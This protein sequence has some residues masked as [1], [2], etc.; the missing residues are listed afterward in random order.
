MATSSSRARASTVTYSESEASAL[1]QQLDTLRSVPETQDQDQIAE[2][3]RLKINAI[4]CVRQSIIN[5]AAPDRI[6]DAFRHQEGFQLCLHVLRISIKLFA[7]PRKSAEDFQLSLEVSISVLSLLSTALQDHW[8]NRKYFRKRVEQ[9]G[10]ATLQ[11]VLSQLLDTWM[12]GDVDI[13]AAQNRLFGALFACAIEGDSMSELFEKLEKH[14]C[15]KQGMEHHPNEGSLLIADRGDYGAIPDDGTL[16]ILKASWDSQFLFHN[17]DAV[18]VALQLWRR[19]GN[20][21]TAGQAPKY[22]NLYLLEVTKY[23]VELST[24]NLLALHGSGILRVVL[25]AFVDASLNL[26]ARLLLRDLAMSLLKIGINE[27]SD[28]HFLYSRAA[29][30][31]EVAELMRVALEQSTTPPFFHFDLSLHGASSIELPDIRHPFPPISGGGY[32]LSIWLQIIR[33]DPES[34]TTIFGAF[35]SSQT[36]F[37]L[38]YLEKDTHNLILQT[39]VTSSKPSVRFKSFVF[40]EGRWYHLCLVHK[41][42]KTTSSSRASLFVDG[43]FVEQIKAQYPA[44]V[45]PAG[46]STDMS[47]ILSPGRKFKPVQ[48][49]LGTP[50]DLAS[51]L[52]NGLVMSQWRLALVHLFNDV[53]S[54]DL[55]AVHKQLG[56]R[57]HGNYQDC[58]G[59]FQTYEASAALNLRNENLHPGKE[60]KSDIVSAIRSKASAILPEAKV[61]LNFSPLSVIFDE[62]QNVLSDAQLMKSLSKAAAKNLRSLSRGGRTVVAVN[63]AVPSIN[64][65]LIQPHGLAVL[66]GD[67]A[68]AVPQSLDDA[69][70]RIG[71][72]AS[73]GLALVE[74]AQGRQAIKRALDILFA[75]IKDNWRNS[76]A[77][78]RENGFGV[79]A[80][81]LTEKLEGGHLDSGAHGKQTSVH[82]EEDYE[83]FALEML[84]TVLEF[85]G[86]QKD[87]PTDSVINNPLA[88]RI[89]IVDLDIWRRSP[90]SVQKLY[91]EQF[92]T[93]GVGSKHRNFNAKRLARMR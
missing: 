73:I 7:T 47:G 25:D 6:R 63:G 68:V 71:G 72:C 56:P 38:V 62:E 87:S 84:S 78:E 27:L 20:R 57:Y 13:A 35:D 88:Y 69:A 42:A 24:H 33:F 66:A 4:S 90:P 91:Y 51:K 85:T 34:H 55:I 16:H 43:E 21:P 10:W 46:P 18:L 29:Y 80:S 40:E 74:A 49:F 37:V 59:S 79:L 83:L 89:L 11:H 5:N 60:E 8:G 26:D 14:L 75:I 9:G 64:E 77:M 30:L 39:S 81:L 53:L 58:L 52:G 67:P 61:L 50:R 82:S 86:Y 2:D 41:R 48:A 1:K 76:E 17:P 23:V 28:A 32:T 22:G 65:A 45:S 93:F 44:S 12:A 70:W 36:C 31:P 19:I 54:D 15:G 92:A 3:I